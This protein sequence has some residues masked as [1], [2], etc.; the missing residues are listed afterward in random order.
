[1]INLFG[2]ANRGVGVVEERI[3][4]ILSA[5]IQEFFFCFQVFELECWLTV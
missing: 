2:S 3:C 1:M 5:E 4:L